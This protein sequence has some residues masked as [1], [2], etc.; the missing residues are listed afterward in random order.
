MRHSLHHSYTTASR[1]KLLLLKLSSYFYVAFCLVFLLL[2]ISVGAKAIGARATSRNPFSTYEDFFPGQPLSAA[3]ARGIS[4]L[5]SAYRG[6]A[7]PNRYCNLNYPETIFSQISLL[8]KV[9]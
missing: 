5:L 7:A 4:C 3:E 6:S 1:Q 8:L 2:L 9:T